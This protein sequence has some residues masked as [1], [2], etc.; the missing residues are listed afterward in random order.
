MVDN[1][2]ASD[3]TPRLAEN[4]ATQAPASELGIEVTARQG[5]Y[6]WLELK[7]FVLSVLTLGIYS[8]W[9]KVQRRKYIAQHT[10]LDGQRFDYIASPIVILR[11]RILVVAIFAALFIMEGLDPTLRLFGTLCLV[12]AAP[13]ALAAS[14][15]FNA[16]NTLYKGFNFTFHGGLKQIYI[17][18]VK[19]YGLSIITLGIGQLVSMQLFSEYIANNTKLNGTPFRFEQERSQYYRLGGV[20]LGGLFFLIIGG[21]LGMYVIKIALGLETGAGDTLGSADWLELAGLVVSMMGYA[22]ILGAIRANLAN[23]FFDGLNFGSHAFLGEI[24]AKKLG[25]IYMTNAIA[26]VCTLGLAIPWAYLRSYKYRM[27]NIAVLAQGPILDEEAAVAA[28]PGNSSDA[29]GDA[30]ADLGFDFGL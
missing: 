11:S 6:C 25:L 23:L 28:T 22:F 20:L 30:F 8:A 9:A 19:A 29:V 17:A 15:A 27:S 14:V 24:K 7:N 13:W 16:R 26:I 12:V 1:Q 4:E 2:S 5:E 18:F 3:P 21:G 10:S